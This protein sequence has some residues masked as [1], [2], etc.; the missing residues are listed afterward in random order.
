[1]SERMRTCAAAY[2]KGAEA[3]SKNYHET[4][5]PYGFTKRELHSWWHAGYQDYLNGYV[6]ESGNPKNEVN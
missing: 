1:M 5:N 4:Q 2:R 6:D 3:A